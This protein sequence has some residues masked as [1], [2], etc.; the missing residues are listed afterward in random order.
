MS[1]ISS[2]RKLQILYF[3]KKNK[4]IKNL[5]NGEKKICPDIGIYTYHSG[6]IRLLLF[7]LVLLNVIVVA[8]SY[9]KLKTFVRTVTIIVVVLEV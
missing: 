5:K 3:S 2:V 7:L 8:V 6:F 1:S 4:E 9:L